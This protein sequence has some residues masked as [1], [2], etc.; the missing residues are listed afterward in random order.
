VVAIINLLVNRVSGPFA[1]TTDTTLQSVDIMAAKAKGRESE[2]GVDEYRYTFGASGLDG[3]GQ[4]FSVTK[5]ATGKPGGGPMAVSM[6]EAISLLQ[7]DGIFRGQ[8]G[9]AILSVGETAVFW[10]MPP[11]SASTAMATPFSFVVLPAKS[12]G[13]VQPDPHAF[14]DHF[15]KCNSGGTSPHSN[16][17]VSFSNIGGDSMLISPCPSTSGSSY[18]H[19]VAFLASAPEEQQHRLWVAVGEQLATRL[20]EVGPDR[21]VWTSTSGLG[22]YWLHVRLDSRPKYYQHRPFTLWPSSQ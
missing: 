12:L 6:G 16:H 4:A 14:A 7:S 11:V 20:I 3:G 13:R 2:L 9:R 8:L 21:P 10:E 19:L 1:L 18:A 5:M 15:V 22:V 17:V